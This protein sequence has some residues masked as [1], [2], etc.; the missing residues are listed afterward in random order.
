MPL[1][2][3]NYHTMGHPKKNKF[4]KKN[5]LHHGTAGTLSCISDA[6]KRWYG[7]PNK[8]VDQAIQPDEIFFQMTQSS[9]KSKY[10]NALIILAFFFTGI[11]AHLSAQTGSEV[12]ERLILGFKAGVNYSNV[13]NKN[14]PVFDSDP[15]TGLGAGIFLAVP[16]GLHF[17]IQPELLFSQKGFKAKGLLFGRTYD[18][19]RTTNYLDIPLFF[20]VKP[21]PFITLLAG[22]QYSYLLQ[23]KNSFTN[24]STSI[25]QQN[26]F[27][28]DGIRRSTLC[29]A[30]GLDIN[31]YH[32][33]VGAR[34]GWDLR[35]NNGDNN[36]VTPHYKNTWYQL[37]IGYRLYQ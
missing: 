9:F 22:P 31:I 6:H 36:S 37:T 29:L 7:F 19:Q 21:A 27:D 5:S 30:T 34:A 1:F 11:C 3:G 8:V 24:G 32:I 15:K 12:R 28:R 16:I 18:L 17:G 10:G 23:Q 26:E 35:S 4:A 2:I 13:Y 25:D 14:G 33:V 20:S